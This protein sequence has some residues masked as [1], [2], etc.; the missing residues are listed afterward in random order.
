MIWRVT[1]HGPR[2]AENVLRYLTGTK[3]KILSHLGYLLDIGACD[4]IIW[5][6]HLTNPKWKTIK[7]VIKHKGLWIDIKEV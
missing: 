4:E 6:D 7:E 3:T 5:I 1:F 2:D